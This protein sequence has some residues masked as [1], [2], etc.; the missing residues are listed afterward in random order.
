MIRIR[1][2]LIISAVVSLLISVQ[3]NQSKDVNVI[4]RV[5]KSTLTLENLKSS[6]PAEYSDQI[7]RDQNVNYVKQWIDRELL[8][9]EALNQKIDK[10]PIIRERLKKMKTDLLA[11]EMLNRYSMKINPDS[12]SDSVVS[13]YYNQN[14]DLFI[15]HTTL[16]KYLDIVLED[17]KTAWE[18]YRSITKDKF[19]SIAAQY[20]RTPTF[21]STNI[22]F[23]SI[24]NV[25][26]E[27]QQS[28]S[29]MTLNSISIPIKTSNGYH[30]IYYIDKLNKGDIC[31]LSEVNKEIVDH[32]VT[33]NQKIL[34]DKVL[35]DLRIKTRVEFDMNLLADS[36]TKQI[37]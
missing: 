24:D 25:P 3:C 14:K 28:I 31:S 11:A 36:L 12:I 30:I 8:F 22:P 34:I 6:I 35:S 27:I 10:D 17:L 37:F 7:T 21:D 19:V 9:Q 13:S 23:I 26:N 29:T 18:V 32:L 20:S 2:Y 5:G 4:A 16:V 1:K 15:R 33:T